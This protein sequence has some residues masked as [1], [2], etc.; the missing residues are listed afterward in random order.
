MCIMPHT[1]GFESFSW[2]GNMRQ[3]RSFFY[4][5]PSLIKLQ[6]LQDDVRKYINV[7]RRTTEKNGKKHSK[8]PKIQ[9]WDLFGCS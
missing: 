4:L 7:Y 6:T 9:R 1:I 8:A 5:I 3:P 2:P